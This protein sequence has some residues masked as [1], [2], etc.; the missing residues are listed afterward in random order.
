LPETIRVTWLDHRLYGSELPVHGWHHIHGEIH[1][2]VTLPDGSRGYLPATATTLWQAQEHD[3]AELA[4]TA[5]GIH[6]LRQLIDALRARS[7]RRRRS[8]ART[9]K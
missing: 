3:R 1:L 6:Q 8:A 5:D 9:S 4:L 7:S 2:L